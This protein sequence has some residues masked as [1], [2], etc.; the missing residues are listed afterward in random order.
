ML[1]F[2]DFPA[3]III[4]NRHINITH[5]RVIKSNLPT[6]YRF[7]LMKLHHLNTISVFCITI[8]SW[9]LRNTPTR[10]ISKQ[11]SEFLLQKSIICTTQ[12]QLHPTARGNPSCRRNLHRTITFSSICGYLRQRFRILCIAR[13][14][15]MPNR[16]QGLGRPFIC[17]DM[18]FHNQFCF[19]RAI[20][21][22]NKVTSINLVRSLIII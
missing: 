5:N 19:I 9:C 14:I 7:H 4:I 21:F 18:V 16:N 12:T 17:T 6:P 15:R 8:Y 2:T 22:D 10:T 1:I 11:R 13:T 20:S 3:T